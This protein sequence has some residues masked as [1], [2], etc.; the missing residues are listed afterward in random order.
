MKVIIDEFL[1]H[2]D[3]S[4]TL[5]GQNNH[6]YMGKVNENSQFSL[7]QYRLWAFH[8]LHCLII[9]EADMEG[10]K[11]SSLNRCIKFKKEY[12]H[13]IKTPSLKKFLAYSQTVKTELLC[14]GIKHANP[15][16]NL[17]SNC[18]G[19][20]DLIA[21]KPITLACIDGSCQNCPT[22]DLECIKHC[23]S[24]MFYKWAKG[25]AIL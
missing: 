15:E 16:A 4:Y 10:I 14:A 25:I 3:I 17:S 12:I 22:I 19:L 6:L 7:K 2:N 13:V 24:I 8:E 1:Y 5:P 9:K 23:D 18:H 11:F 20:L 21:Y